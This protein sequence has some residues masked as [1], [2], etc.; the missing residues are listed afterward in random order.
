MAQVRVTRLAFVH[1]QHPDLE[2]ALKFFSDFGTV[3]EQ[4][5]PDKVYLRGFGI[6]PYIYVAEQSPDS[7]RHF[8]GGYWVVSSEEDLKKAASQ[9]GASA[10]YDNDGPGGG[11]VVTVRDPCGFLVGFVFGQQLRNYDGTTG[12]LE[13]TS[14]TTNSPFDK[15]R[16]GNVRRYRNG[17]SPVHKL[18]HYGY[19]VPRSK[20]METLDWYHR[21]MNLKP[22]DTVYDPKTLEDETTFNHIDLGDEYTDHHSFFLAA[23][24]DHKPAHIHHSSFEISDFDTQNLGHDWLRLHGWTNCWGI[25]RHVLGSQIFDYWFDASGNIVEHYADGDLVNQHTPCGREH[26]APGR[27]EDAG[28]TL[29]AMPDVESSKPA[30][31]GDTT[32]PAGQIKVAAA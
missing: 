1:Y 3:E 23:G 22:T 10:I 21:L 7:K 5:T 11:K 28:K 26:A 2:K 31:F 18:G 4:R 17:P 25:G 16:K 13:Q 24:P 15:P 19:V 32:N 30:D 9:P 8:V 6:D 29:N 20:F 14:P 12:L 27:M